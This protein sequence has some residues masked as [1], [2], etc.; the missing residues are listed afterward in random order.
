M[1][2]EPSWGDIRKL[3][4][5][6][7]VLVNGNLCQDD[8][9]RLTKGDRLRVLVQSAKPLP[10]ADK[11]R[12]V[13]L[14]PHLLLVEKPAGLLSVRHAEE[15]AW[16]EAKKQAMPT[17]E[18]LLPAALAQAGGG[19][20]T[21]VIAVHR[22][23]R[24][25]SGLMVFARTRDTELELVRLFKNHTLERKYITIVRGQMSDPAVIKTFIARDRGDGKRGSLPVGADTSDAQEAITHVEPLER[26]KVVNQDEEFTIVECT[27][28]TGRTHQIRIHLSEQ[29]HPVVGDKIYYAP[30]SLGQPELP[31]SVLPPRQALHAAS[32]AFEHPI[33]KKPLTFVSELSVDLRR[34]LDRLVSPAQ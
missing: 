25:T 20:N 24:D 13:H 11:L 28:E 2:P 27:L 10:T 14:D 1:K 31:D 12:L 15:A 16:S 5:A 30:T 34:W 6:R 18:D 4:A 32:L 3:L 17:L 33:T 26:V 23:D 8:A 19:S 9:R 29:G 21:N 22:L 7:K